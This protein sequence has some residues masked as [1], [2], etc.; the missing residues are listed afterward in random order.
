M[1]FS[2][3]QDIFNTVF[4]G[5]AGQG[6]QQSVNS[7]G[8]CQYRG[9]DGMKC[10]AGHLIPDAEYDLYFEGSAVVGVPYFIR[11]YPEAARIFIGKLQNMHDYYWEYTD[12]DKVPDLMKT[13]FIAFAARSN[14][15]VPE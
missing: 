9:N 8:R 7:D 13:D 12:R 1:D 3:Y 5:L 4:A 10:A 15:K 2:Q 11:R 14:L 6:W